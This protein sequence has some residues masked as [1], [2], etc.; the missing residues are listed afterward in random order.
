VNCVPGHIQSTYS[1]AYI[2][3]NIR[4]NV[5]A[6]LLAIIGHF[7]A[8]YTANLVPHTAHI[9]QF[10]L[11]ELWSRPYTRYLHFR[12]FRLQYSSARICAAIGGITTIQCAPCCK[13]GAKYRTLPPVN[14]IC[15]VVPVI[16]NAFA[17]PYIQTSI[18]SCRYLHCRR[19]Y[20]VN[21]M[22]DILQSGCRIQRTTTSLHY[23]YCGPGHIQSVYS[24]AYSGHNIQLN[25]SALLLEIWRQ[26][27]ACRTTK[28]APN[29]AHIPQFT[30]CELWSRKYTIYLQLFIFR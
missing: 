19:R 17:T 30:L 15:T 23:V 11:C 4:W 21:T 3:F 8:S 18:F 14:S 26:F 25:V 13:L 29:A 24:S 2:C 28:F 20:P 12:I 9:L 7:E 27:N 6:L 1:S 22:R 5:S 16:Y 10:T